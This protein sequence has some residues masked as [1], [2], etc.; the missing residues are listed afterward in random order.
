MDRL[1]KISIY[2]GEGESKRKD[3]NDLI[4]SLVR[5]GYEVYL[6]EEHVCFKLGHGDV[7]ESKRE[8]N[9][10]ESRKRVEDIIKRDKENQ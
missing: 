8:F 6:T 9:Y 4:S 2:S 5:I 1:L 3:I 10:K 7:V